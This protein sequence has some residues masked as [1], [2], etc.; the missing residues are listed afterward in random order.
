MKLILRLFLIFAVPRATATRHGHAISAE[1]LPG[2]FQ[3]LKTAAA[4]AA[5]SF[6]H[7]HDWFRFHCSSYCRKHVL[8][9]LLARYGGASVPASRLVPSAPFLNN[10][11]AIISSGRAELPLRPNKKT[12]RIRIIKRSHYRF[13]DS[14]GRPSAVITSRNLPPSQWLCASPWIY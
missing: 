2:N 4:F 12:A 9:F 3:Y 10:H 1:K 6:L 5:G 7:S 11:P 14:T 13:F 8:P